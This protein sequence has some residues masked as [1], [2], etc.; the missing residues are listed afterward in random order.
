MKKSAC[1]L[2]ILLVT[3][4]IAV[5]GGPGEPSR[6]DSLDQPTIISPEWD[7][8][9]IEAH[10]AFCALPAQEL[11]NHWD[12]SD[13][14]PYSFDPFQFDDT[15]CLQLVNEASCG[16][17]HPVSNQRVTSE[18]G[19]RRYR[20]HYGIDIDLNTGDAVFAAFD[21]VVRV[22]KYSSTYGYVVVIRHYNGLETLYSHLSR[23]Q[24]KP[25]QEVEAGHQVGLGGRTG[26]ATGSHLHFEVRYKGWSIDPRLLI[27]FDSGTLTAT[28]IEFTPEWLDYMTYRST[29]GYYEIKRG[30]T[31]YGIAEQHGIT[32]NQLLALNSMSSRSVI[33][34]GQKLRIR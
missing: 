19:P 23:L 12:E 2:I 9:G 3:L 25:G 14:H 34:P 18:F 20:W 30:D 26:R 27:D 1:V 28:S 24:V 33:H 8:D 29:G 16:F 5:A 13:I 7:I 22:A 10:T 6:G 11:Y 17:V 4:Q 21:G 15:V 32:L 31:L